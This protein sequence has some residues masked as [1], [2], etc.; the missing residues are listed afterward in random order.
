MQ[1]Q[2]QS[3][4]NLIRQNRIKTEEM[5]QYLYEKNSPNSLSVR[6]K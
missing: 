5:L 1:L 6:K 4:Q 2:Y 3:H